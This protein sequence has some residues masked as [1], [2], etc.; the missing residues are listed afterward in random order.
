MNMLLFGVSCKVFLKTKVVVVVVVVILFVYLFI[1]FILET[2][3]Q[4]ANA[5]A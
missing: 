5:K 2:E 3:G 4:K 1:T